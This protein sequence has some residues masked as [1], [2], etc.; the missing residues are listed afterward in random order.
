MKIFAWP[1]GA[2]VFLLFIQ[3][4]WLINRP[5]QGHYLQWQGPKRDERKAWVLTERK[6]TEILNLPKKI[7][8][9]GCFGVK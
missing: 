8:L 1:C 3:R 6:Q 9:T 2:S 5:R 4:R 7:G